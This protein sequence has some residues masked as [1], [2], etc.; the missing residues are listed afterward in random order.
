[1]DKLPLI[2]PDEPYEY[3]PLTRLEVVLFAVFV[4]VLVVLLV[5]VC[6]TH[7]TGG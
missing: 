3:Q 4:S 5:A 2:R 6:Y 1:M 7:R